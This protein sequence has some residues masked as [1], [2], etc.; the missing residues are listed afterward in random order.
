MLAPF[1]PYLHCDLRLQPR[2]G[3][4][5][6]LSCR[7][8]VAWRNGAAPVWSLKHAHF[9]GD[10]LIIGLKIK[11]LQRKLRISSRPRQSRNLSLF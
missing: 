11:P 8:V 4:Y 2:G 5:E 6:L 3:I 1:L 10:I 9:E 7:C